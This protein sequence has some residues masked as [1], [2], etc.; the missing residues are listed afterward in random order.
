MGV[1]SA[2]GPMDGMDRRERDEHRSKHKHRHHKHRHRDRDGDGMDP[3]DQPP[4]D[5]SPNRWMSS[6]PSRVVSIEST[7]QSYCASHPGGLQSNVGFRRQLIHTCLH[8]LPRCNRRQMGNAQATTCT[9]FYAALFCSWVHQTHANGF[10]VTLF[11][12]LW[13][14]LPGMQGLQIVLHLP[15]MYPHPMT[16]QWTHR[17]Q[18]AGQAKLS[19]LGLLLATTHP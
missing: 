16:S 14:L 19:F 3:A 9:S 10:V 17:P 18:M 5:V 4:N 15:D 1:G 2:P 13:L 12:Q 8:Y 11:P 7:A 6:T